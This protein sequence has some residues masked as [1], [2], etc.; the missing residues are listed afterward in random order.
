MKTA[1]LDARYMLTP[2]KADFYPDEMVVTIA[3]V[4]G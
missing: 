2:Q 4:L 3:T 1:N